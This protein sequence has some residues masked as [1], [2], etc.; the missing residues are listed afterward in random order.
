MNTKHHDQLAEEGSRSVCR[1]TP[2]IVRG[3]AI[4][5]SFQ[6][7][8]AKDT[9]LSELQRSQSNEGLSIVWSDPEICARSVESR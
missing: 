4:L 9:L 1:A 3:L 7:V 2:S 5:V 6:V 8:S